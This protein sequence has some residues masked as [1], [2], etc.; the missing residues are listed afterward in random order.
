MSDRDLLDLTEHVPPVS[1]ELLDLLR[2]V[3]PVTPPT[4]TSTEREDMYASGHRE[5][6]EYLIALR[7]H[8]LQRARE[9]GI[10]TQTSTPDQP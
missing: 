10:T 6:L 7:E 4:P 3:F 5:V 2:E 9:R 1:K 8:Q